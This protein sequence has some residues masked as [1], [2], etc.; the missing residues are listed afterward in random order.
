MLE[1][2]KNRLKLKNKI[3]ADSKY[4]RYAL[5][6]MVRSVRPPYNSRSTSE[7][8]T[9]IIDNERMVL[10]NRKSRKVENLKF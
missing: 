6:L 10:K 5:T 9:L 1:G 7:N 8:S 4:G 2:C 3:N